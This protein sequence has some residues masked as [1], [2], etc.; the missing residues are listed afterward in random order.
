MLVIK[1]GKL[2]TQ[3]QSGIIDDP[4][5][6]MEGPWIQAVGENIPIPEDVTLIDAA[7][8]YI[9]P[10]FIDAH[11]HIGLGE[12]IYAIEGDDINETSDPVTAE[13]QAL[14]GINFA[15]LAFK[16]ALEGGV[17]R[18]VSLPGRDE[19]EKLGYRSG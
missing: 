17:T 3:D 2:L 4:V 1:G 8:K 19:K 16:D 10:G 12:E 13:L 9:L 11:T 6:I 5:I 15:D 7:G 18:S 14:D